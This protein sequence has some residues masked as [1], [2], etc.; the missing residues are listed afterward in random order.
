MSTAAAH[1]LRRGHVPRQGALALDLPPAYR[2]DPGNDDRDQ[3]ERAAPATDPWA[4]SPPELVKG[5]AP[6]RSAVL[7]TALLARRLARC[8]RDVR[9]GARGHALQVVRGSD[10]VRVRV[11]VST[12]RS[13]GD[14]VFR[15]TR[16]SVDDGRRRLSEH[17][18]GRM[19]WCTPAR[20]V[21]VPQVT[22]QAVPAAAVWFTTWGGPGIG[23]GGYDTLAVPGPTPTRGY[24]PVPSR[25]LVLAPA[26]GWVTFHPDRAPGGLRGSGGPGAAGTK[27][28]DR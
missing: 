7:A 24:L 22:G 20:R 14:L 15:E 1:R 16:A 3:A 6:A 4:G 10:V 23:A 17:E 8:G 11:K 21:L 25:Q 5:A 2:P 9:P 12:Q 28:L 27:V 13:S 26:D 18:L 19:T